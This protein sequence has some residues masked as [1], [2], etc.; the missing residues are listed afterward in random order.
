MSNVIPMKV[1]DLLK[2]IANGTIKVSDQPRKKG[3]QPKINE[4]IRIVGDTV[5]MRAA[6]DNAKLAELEMRAQAIVDQQS[7]DESIQTV[8]TQKQK[9]A[10]PPPTKFIHSGTTV[11]VARMSM[12]NIRDALAPAIYAPYIDDKG[13]HLRILKPRFEAVKAYGLEVEKHI[14]MFAERYLADGSVS[15]IL[16]GQKGSGKTMTAEATCN[17]LLDQGLPVI[18]MDADIP[19]PLLH[20]QIRDIG[21]CV[22]F[23]D[24]FDKRYTEREDRERLL[25]MFSD[26]SLGNVSF[27][28]AGND[29]Y[30]FSDFLLDRPSRFRYLIQ[31]KGIS[32]YIVKEICDKA[33]ISKECGDLIMRYTCAHQAS[34]DVVHAVVKAAKAVDSDIDKLIVQVCYMNV[35]RFT[36]ITIALVNVKSEQGMVSGVHIR[37]NKEGYG[38]TVIHEDGAKVELTLKEICNDDFAKQTFTIGTFKFQFRLTE[39]K[40]ATEDSL[41]DTTRYNKEDV[42][43]VTVEPGQYRTFELKGEDGETKVVTED[44]YSRGNNKRRMNSFRAMGSTSPL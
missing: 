33:G 19:P 24:E 39:N 25:T 13:I 20:N 31:Y 42:V 7:I 16:L 17:Y 15:A 14:S 36:P 37:Q 28:I 40:W 9:L 5:A 6:A 26:A 43:T 12:N 22:L 27:I 8:N 44:E 10:S 1:S 32:P 41:A 38:F 3:G 35:P 4:R 21:A 2:G 18:Y 11:D 29:K 23:I 34:F 30:R